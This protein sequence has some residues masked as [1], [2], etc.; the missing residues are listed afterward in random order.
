METD[1]TIS[2][3]AHL[4]L[5]AD[6]IAFRDWLQ[7]KK[8]QRRLRTKTDST[9]AALSTR[10]TSPASAAVLP[11]SDVKSPPPRS[12]KSLSVSLDY[13]EISEPK[14]VIISAQQPQQTELDALLQQRARSQ[15]AFLAWVQR[16]EEEKVNLEE[17]QRRKQARE[18]K[19]AQVTQQQE[20]LR[21]KRQQEAIR[22]WQVEK[23][24][25][26]AKL[27]SL[28]DAQ[29]REQEK[30]N[31]EKRRQSEDAFNKW[32]QEKLKQQQQQQQEQNKNIFNPFVAH[33]QRWIDV[34]PTIVKYNEHIDKQARRKS[35]NPPPQELLSPPH[36]YRDFPLYQSSA[37]NYIIKYPSQ[38]A[39]G[40]VGLSLAMFDNKT[41]TQS[42]P[43]PAPREPQVKQGVVKKTIQKLHKQKFK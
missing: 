26:K 41:N 18:S 33:L 42:V 3:F 22:K 19:Q 37:P 17:K 40:G 23:D 2:H 31:E 4:D 24:L 20:S 5:H 13:E 15:Q 34:N 9:S 14:S 10:T 6:D 21:R 1:A 16:K 27:E 30:I 38:V 32:A 36:L 43:P 11:T 28:Q 7:R 12:K 29:K 39:S 25:E 8:A 35:R